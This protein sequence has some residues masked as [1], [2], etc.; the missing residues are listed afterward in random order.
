MCNGRMLSRTRPV[1]LVEADDQ[2]HTDM[3][4]LVAAL[5][6]KG[7]VAL[8]MRQ[9]RLTTPSQIIALHCRR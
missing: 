6:Q 2:N 8:L 3:E 9:W 7:A 5:Q 4:A 1:L